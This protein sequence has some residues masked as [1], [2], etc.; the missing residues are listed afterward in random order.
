MSLELQIKTIIVSFLF[1][2]YF[3]II[4]R[5]SQ[6]IIY[7]KYEIVKLLG[8]TMIILINTVIYF[9][10]IKKINEGIFHIYEILFIVL[11]MLFD[12]II[13]RYIID[14]KYKR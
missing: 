4:L 8:T 11:G 10:V 14:L 1:G 12:N 9:L 7:N 5:M 13:H 2:I 3:L 6:K